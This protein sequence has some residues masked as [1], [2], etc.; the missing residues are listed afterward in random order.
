L[1]RA[2]RESGAI[3]MAMREARQF[4]DRAMAALAELPDE[5]ERIA[6]QGLASYVVEREI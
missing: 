5:P 3:E 1:I 6:L 2:I 4:V